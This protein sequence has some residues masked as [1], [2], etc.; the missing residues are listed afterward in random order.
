[1]ISGAVKS[2]PLTASYLL[3]SAYGALR[4]NWQQNKG[5]KK[6][7]LLLYVT[8]HSSSSLQQWFASISISYFLAFPVPKVSVP[9]GGGQQYRKIPEACELSA[10][11]DKQES[12]FKFY[13]VLSLWS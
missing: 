6:W 11:A 7:L 5:R 2:H 12:K 9:V 13:R 10:S 1:V 4:G 8:N 3:G